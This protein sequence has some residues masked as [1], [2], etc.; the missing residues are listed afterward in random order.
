[1]GK[2]GTT[3]GGGPLTC[4]VA[5]EFLNIIEDEKLLERVRSVGDYLQQ[6]LNALTERF[7]VAI[8]ARGMGFMQALELNVPARPLVEAALGEGV[9]FNATQETVLRF[10][11]PFLLQEKHVDKGIRVLRKLLKKQRSARSAAHKLGA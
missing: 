5:L 7:E 6:E 11:P 9:L 1:M 3:F 2:H 4:R 8:A 10:L